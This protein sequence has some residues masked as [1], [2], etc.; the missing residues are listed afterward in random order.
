MYAYS[1][2]IFVG[3]GPGFDSL[4]RQPE[5]FIDNQ[6]LYLS[7]DTVYWLNNG[8]FVFLY[9][10]NAIIGHK[11]TITGDTSLYHCSGH[12]T[13]AT[14]TISIVGLDSMV[15]GS[16]KFKKLSLGASPYWS[17]GYTILKNIG[18]YN[19]PF[20]LP[21]C[22]TIDGNI[23]FPEALVCYHDSVRGWIDFGGSGMCYGIA[24]AI[25]QT[26][27]ELIPSYILYPN[28]TTGHIYIKTE[29]NDVYQVCIYNIVGSLAYTG[30]NSIDGIDIS[31]Y[32]SGI[33]ICRI[34]DKSRGE[35]IIKL[36]KM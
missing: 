14:D 16:H 4:Y 23:N 8:Q 31:A 24:T 7:G 15:I 36:I 29:A 17:L 18:A 32:Q 20:P 2:I 5:V 1:Y 33:Y 26:N 28:P 10:F 12:T 25:A 27:L 22:N 35:S 3:P 11:W 13:P 19:T 6:Y 30:S 9:D 21:K 34:T